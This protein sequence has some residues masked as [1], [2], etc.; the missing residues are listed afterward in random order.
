MDAD[1]TKRQLEDALLQMTGRP[2]TV[3]L[4]VGS[5]LWEAIGPIRLPPI[6][7]TEVY[8]TWY[9]ILDKAGWLRADRK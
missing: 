4:A 9:R 7:A 3:R 2:W 6:E 5:H 1:R 8:V